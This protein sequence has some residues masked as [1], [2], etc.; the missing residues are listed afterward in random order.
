MAYVPRRFDIPYST[1]NIPVIGLFKYQQLL[2]FRIES[3]LRRMRWKVFW[4]KNKDKAKDFES[5]G[6]QS[7]V[8]A[9]Y[10]EE[11]KP[12]ED[13]LLKLIGEIETRPFNNQ[14][15]A[16]MKDDIRVLRQM[17]DTV[18]VAS[19]KTSNFYLMEANQYQE[20]LRQEIRKNYR[21]VGREIVDDIDEEAANFATKRKL[22]NR[23]EGI[24]LKTS[25]LTIKDH[26]EDFPQ[27]TGYRLIKPTK[28]KIGVN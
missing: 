3:L 7:P 26:K 14:L 17:P 24:A 2:T 10:C 11:L 13:D 4:D 12:F 21:K 6:F 18:V 20:N 1:K 28:P 5:F 16:R 25:F 8:A 27:K 19:D 23:I 22:D 15:Q 9:P